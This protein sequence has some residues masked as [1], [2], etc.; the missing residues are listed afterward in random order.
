[1]TSQFSDA[2]SNAYDLLYADKKYEDEALYVAAKVR[3]AHP[4][5]KSILELGSGTGR[6]ARLMCDQGFEV[7]GIE[8]SVGMLDKARETPRESLTYVEGDIRTCEV[9][10]KFDAVV[11][12]FHVVSYLTSN[13]DIL[14]AFANARRHLDPGGILAFDFWYGPAVLT[15]KPENRLRQLKSGD[16]EVTRFAHTDLDFNKN[17]ASVFYNLFIR[18]AKANTL[19]TQDETHYMRYFFLPELMMLLGTSDFEF[20]SAE[21]WMTSGDLGSTTWNGFVLAKAK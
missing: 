14:A 4:A 10:R 20:L 1:M 16:L 9:G 19:H 15:C 11:S 7:V 18:D 13:D 3:G 12:L 17:I 5:A 8:R 2:Y 21:E 6:H